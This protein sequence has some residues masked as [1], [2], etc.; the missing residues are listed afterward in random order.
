MHIITVGEVVRVAARG[1]VDKLKVLRTLD[2]GAGKL[3]AADGTEQ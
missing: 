1:A 3:W 2:A